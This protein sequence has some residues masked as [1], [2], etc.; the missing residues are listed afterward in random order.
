MNILNEYFSNNIPTSEFFRT[1]C[2]QRIGG[3]ASRDVYEF[4][5]DSSLV[6]KFEVR[7]SMFQNVIEW[8]TWKEVMETEHAAWFAPC[9]LISPCGTV[10]LQKRTE[11]IRD[12][13]PEKMPSYFTDFKYTNYGMYNDHIVC[14]DYGTNRMVVTGMN[15]RM[16]TANWWEEGVDS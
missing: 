13:Y 1:M 8:E 12:K 2:G 15:K 7:N 6:V 14:H 10:L 11:K 9:K 3:G 4:V 5:P 16:R